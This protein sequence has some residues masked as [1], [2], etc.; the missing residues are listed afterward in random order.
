VPLKLRPYGA[1]QIC[2]LLLL[3]FY[4]PIS[5]KQAIVLPRLKKL[6]VDRTS[7]RPISNLSFV[8]KLLKRVAAIRFVGH[9]ERNSLF[10]VHQS[11]YR[12]GHSTETAILCV[13]NDIVTAVNSKRIVGLVLLDISAAFDTVD[14]DTLHS[15]LQRHFSVF[16]PAHSWVKSYLSDRTVNY[17]VNG[18][19]SGLVAVNCSVPQGSVLANQVYFIH[20]GRRHSIPPTTS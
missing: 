18:V 11:S 12:H 16:N 17:L 19:S 7:N 5:Q 9:S 4:F 2:L 13:H 10:L 1:I 15:V 20:R 6:T 14:H 8:S 3:L